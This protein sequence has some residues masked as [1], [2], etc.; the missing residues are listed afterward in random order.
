LLAQHLGKFLR[1]DAKTKAQNVANEYVSCQVC[2]M[3][4]MLVVRYVWCQVC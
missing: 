2:L 4:G 1:K 3:S